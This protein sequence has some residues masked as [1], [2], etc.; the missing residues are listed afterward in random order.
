MN[1]INQNGISVCQAGKE[2]YT[3]FVAG[4]F[5]GKEYIQYDYRTP[6]GILFSTVAPTLEECRE[7]RDEW[8]TEN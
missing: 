8:L 2:N 6:E 3:T 1:T 7:Q 5:R 4:A